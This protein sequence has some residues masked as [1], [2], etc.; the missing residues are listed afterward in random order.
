MFRDS[1]HEPN[2]WEDIGPDGSIEVHF[3]ALLAICPPVQHGSRS[4]VKSRSWTDEDVGMQYYVFRRETVGRFSRMPILTYEMFCLSD[5]DTPIAQAWRYDPMRGHIVCGID[6]WFPGEPI[7][8]V[9]DRLLH[10][11]N[12][13]DNYNNPNVTAELKKE[14]ARAVEARVG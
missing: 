13:E 3:D 1:D 12:T 7:D 11:S 8:S 9:R 4:V 6:L 5:G 2:A 10:P 14:L